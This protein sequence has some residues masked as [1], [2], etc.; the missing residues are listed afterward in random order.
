[1]M[2]TIKRILEPGPSDLELLLP[3]HAAGTLDVRDARRIE[4]A[5]ARDPE[6]A[7]QYA[8]IREEYAATISLNENLG[9][10]SIRAMQKL[11]AAIDAERAHR[12]DFGDAGVPGEPGR[13]GFPGL[14]PPW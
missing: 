13:A 7:R 11:F 3:W 2:A 9:T 12:R 4:D 6:L 5:L 1:M 8:M 10:P 14:E